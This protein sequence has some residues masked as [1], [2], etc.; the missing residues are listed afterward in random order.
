[1]AVEGYTSGIYRCYQ[2]SS[3]FVK[4]AVKHLSENVQKTSGIGGICK[5]AVFAIDL[6]NLSGSSGPSTALTLLR[7]DLKTVT[8][9]LGAVSLVSRMRDWICPE[10]PG[11]PGKEHPFWMNPG[12]SK[13]KIVGKAFLTLG[14]VCDAVKFLGSI[15]L[16]S[17]G[18][19][20][21]K[22]GGMPVLSLVKLTSIIISAHANLIDC[23]SRWRHIKGKENELLVKIDHLNQRIMKEKEASASAKIKHKQKKINSAYKLLKKEKNSVLFSSACE[24]LKIASLSLS[25][26]VTFAGVNT[27]SVTV[28]VVSLGI[29]SSTLGMFNSNSG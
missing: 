6:A 4:G 28:L 27:G 19:L 8:E 26:G 21:M 7:G 13:A 15:D 9:L 24:V 2:V 3:N 17:L 16:I 14:S 1:M 5:V 23:R 29:L 20:S 22:F 10:K 25:I 11:V 12:T 18:I